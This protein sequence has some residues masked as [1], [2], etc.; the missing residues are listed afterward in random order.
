MIRI[1]LAIF[2]IAALPAADNLLRNGDFSAVDAAG[3]PLG[4]KK[5]D[6][7]G[8]LV[9]EPAAEGRLPVL[10]IDVGQAAGDGMGSVGQKVAVPAGVEKLVLIGTVRSSAEGLGVLQVKLLQGGKEQ[11]R[12]NS[13]ASGTAWQ[14]LRVEF[15][16]AGASELNVQ[17]R[18]SLSARA[19]GQQVWFRDLRL[20]PA[21]P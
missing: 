12:V 20:V 17:C 2:A 19:A 4:W 18:F 9:I 14:E 10:R 6:G 16:S 5:A 11:Q 8:T 13:P 1:I 7:P 21:A 15:A 3:Q